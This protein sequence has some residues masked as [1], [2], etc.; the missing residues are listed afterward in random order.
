MGI[1]AIIGLL[2]YI[3]FFKEKTKAQN[4]GLVVP[5]T[6]GS[7]P[8]TA[9]NPLAPQD[10]S[11]VSYTPPPVI[12]MPTEGTGSA[13]F[14]SSQLEVLKTD[15]NALSQRSNNPGALFWD[16]VTNWKGL[17]SIR[18]KAGQ[19]I[20]FDTVDNGVRAQCMTL[21]NYSKKHGIYTLNSLTARYAPLGHG[22]NNPI[23]YAQ[24]LASYLGIE[25]TTAFN[26]D[27]NRELLAGVAY[28]IHR[29]EAGYFWVPRSKFLEWAP[30]V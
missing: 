18:S 5:L 25:P 10:I 17:D 26:L 14:D 30:K 28:Y 20:Y 11:N 4:G 7:P 27:S 23:A 15:G 12:T 2:V 1:L 29:V 22:G 21:K 24:T 16:G 3:F 6:P 19:I 8:S 9:N 13:G